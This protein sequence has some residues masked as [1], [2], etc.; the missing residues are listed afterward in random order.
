MNESITKL[1]V[2][3]KIPFL[4]GKYSK[5]TI[6]EIYQFDPEFLEPNVCKLLGTYIDPIDFSI[7]PIPTPCLYSRIYKND[8]YNWVIL[9]YDNKTDYVEEGYK[10][11]EDGYE[12]S[13][14]NFIFSEKFIDKMKTMKGVH[15]NTTAEEWDNALDPSRK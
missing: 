6:A 11:L 15:E 9:P 8:K 13:S 12:L 3:G 2:T 5:Y 4:R 1:I 10:F 14:I 7:L